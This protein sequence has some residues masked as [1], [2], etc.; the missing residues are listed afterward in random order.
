MPLAAVPL[1]PKGPRFRSPL[2][3][4]QYEAT[5]IGIAAAFVFCGDG[6]RRQ[7]AALSFRQ[8]SISESIS[9]IDSALAGVNRKCPDI[10]SG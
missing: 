3:H 5:A 1:P 6:S 10:V 8:T 7:D 9:G 2:R 4:Q